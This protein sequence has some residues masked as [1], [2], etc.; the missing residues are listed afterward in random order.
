MKNISVV[1]LY[2]YVTIVLVNFLKQLNTYSLWVRRNKKVPVLFLL[3][4]G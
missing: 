4:D 2:S 1:G 3:A